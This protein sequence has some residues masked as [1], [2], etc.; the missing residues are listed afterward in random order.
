MKYL[1]QIK[2]PR[3][4]QSGVVGKHPVWSHC[5]GAAGSPRKTDYC[6]LSSRQA[7]LG[8]PRGSAKV[9]SPRSII[10]C[11]ILLTWARRANGIR[12]AGCQMGGL[13][14]VLIAW[15]MRLVDPNSEV[16]SANTSENS[17]RSV[18][19]ARFW[20]ADRSVSSTCRVE[21]SSWLNSP[22]ECCQRLH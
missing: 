20:S 19:S 7:P 5:S 8:S 22:V 14:P 18:F 4:R 11:T 1:P 12:L 17:V 21:S 15:A 10:C 13:L 9:R 6:H 3:C 2:S 16:S